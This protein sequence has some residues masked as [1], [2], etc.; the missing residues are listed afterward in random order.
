[1]REA[2]I[3]RGCRSLCVSVTEVDDPHSPK[4]LDFG[5]AFLSTKSS[6]WG[7]SNTTLPVSH[8]QRFSSRL[9]WGWP[10]QESWWL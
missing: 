2:F 4:A 10:G 8:P 7:A 6:V 9:S 1:M 3:V 5:K